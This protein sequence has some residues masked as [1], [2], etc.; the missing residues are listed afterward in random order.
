MTDWFHTLTGFHESSY[1]STQA[2]LDVVGD[3]LRS[4]VNG[5]SYAIGELETPSLAD[6]RTRTASLRDEQRGRLRVSTIVADVASLHRDPAHHGA[7]F[8]VASQFN[9][10]EMTGPSVTPEDGVARYAHDP[11]QGPACAVAAG[12]ATIYRNYCVPVAQWPGQR[13]QTASR[14]IDCLAGIGAA[15]GNT[16]HTLWTMRNGYAL[17]T[18]SG[19]AAITTRLAAMADTERDDLRARL[20]VGLHWNVQVTSAGASATQRV[21]QAF[22]STLPVSYSAVPPARWQ[23]FATLVLEGAYEA[24][25]LAAL[26]QGQRGGTNRVFLTRLGGGAFGNDSAWIHG[27]LRRALVLMRGC[28]LDV[29]IVSRGSP[30]AELLRLVGE[31]A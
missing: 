27:A 5:Q 29:R 14:Q 3:T 26:L 31:F 23:A 21:S 7:L 8:Q 24:T 28:D 4:C 30:G 11:T 19:L 22:C 25:L 12:A 2:N 1:A 9:L 13:G 10:L 16:S 6:L 18:E 15:L 20:A 17:C